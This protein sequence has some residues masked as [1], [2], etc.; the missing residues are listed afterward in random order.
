MY[1]F[2]V[3]VLSYS[4]NLGINSGSLNVEYNA[5]ILPLLPDMVIQGYTFESWTMDGKVVTEDTKMPNHD[6]EVFGTFIEKKVTVS[7]YDD[8]NVIFEKEYGEGVAL[9]TVLNESEI[10]NYISSESAN[11]YT[12]S[13]MLDG[14]IANGNT[15]VISN[16]VLTVKKT[17][18][19]YILTFKNGEDVISS[20]E[21]AFGDVISYPSIENKTENGVEYIFVWEDETYNGKSMPNMNLVIKGNYQEKADAPIY[22]GTFVTSAKEINSDIF[23]INNL[24]DFQNVSLAECVDGKD[25]TITVPADKYLVEN[26]DDITEEEL[27][28]YMST[29]FYPHCFL[30]PSEILKTYQLKLIQGGISE[31]TSSFTTDGKE[32]NINGTQYF[33]YG[34]LNKDAFTPDIEDYPYPYKIQLIK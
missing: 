4:N 21:I 23:D 11:G 8:S 26:Q 14:N 6:A 3:V 25:I 12:V 15:I 7:I 9:N 27:E 19:T 2:S 22:Y 34:F 20:S 32:I 33:L 13:F 18:N 10:L 31:V 5:N 29:H 28:E 16:I 30:I 17:P 24:K 1:S